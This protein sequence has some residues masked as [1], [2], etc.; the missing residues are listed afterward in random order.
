[1]EEEN[2]PILLTG[3]YDNTIK[4][5]STDRPTWEC[6]KTIEVPKDVQN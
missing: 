3:S 4:I 1:M 5:W 2:K 6:S